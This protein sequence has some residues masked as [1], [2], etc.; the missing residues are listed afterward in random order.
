MR[1]R[2]DERHES[3]PTGQVKPPSIR[4]GDDRAARW[5]RILRAAVLPAGALIGLSAGG[6]AFLTD[7]ALSDRIWLVALVLTGGPVVIRMSRGLLAG[8]FAA[9]I[10]ATLAI[11]T[12]IILGQPLAGL[13]VVL[14]QT[15]GEALEKYAE[16][17]AS[18]A[19]RALERDA[20]RIAHRQRGDTVEDIPVESIAVG[21]ALI[22]RPGEML[23]C[24]GEVT[25]GASHL[26]TSRVT[27]EPL[28]VRVRAGDHVRSG[29]MNGE[30]SLGLRAT[31]ISAESLYARIVELVRSAEASKAPLQRL[32]DRYATYFTPFTLAMCAVA[33][34]V[35][36]DANRVLSVLVVATPC[37]LILAT[38]IAIIGGINRAASR[39]I[40]IRTGGALERLSG[41]RAIVFDKTGTMTI[42][43][44]EVAVVTSLEGRS[45]DE[46]LQLAAAV[47]RRSSHQL[48]RSVVEA[49]LGR[50]MVPE[51]VHVEESPGRGVKGRVGHHDVA[52]GALSY[53]RDVTHAD[54]VD[55]L[56]K[57][58]T[59]GLRAYVALDGR[60]SGFIEFADRLRA[61]AADEVARLRA[62]GIERI[63]LLSGDRA[64]NARAVARDVGIAEV[65][66]DLLPQEKVERVARISR[67]RP[68]A[69]VGDGTNDAPALARAD[70]GIALA[71]HGGGIT[72][73]AADIVVLSDSL[74]RVGEAIEISRRTMMIARQSIGVGLGLS[75]AA[76]VAAVAGHITPVLGALLQEVIDIA[77]IL[78]ALR[79]GARG[80]AVG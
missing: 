48:A 36:G 74:D 22:V 69:M 65:E 4:L 23:P 44:P 45:S 67:H 77:V 47:E 16:G 46:L 29:T 12:A 38:P 60:L 40:I 26:D 43:R 3:L 27:G 13:I 21:D 68:V 57:N 66:G 15:G 35:S 73:E 28:P 76:M 18:A 30:G 33:W 34:F 64:A 50:G 51:A 20:P 7:R 11:I 63:A 80:R 53:V 78:N 72:A 70:V 9:D 32:A 52:V 31:A 59:A 37:P 54:V 39:Q 75:A 19:V 14:M 6:A 5:R 62:L 17:R 10:V 56:T 55:E 58:G 1:S 71:G 79:A 2:D 41:V 49:A 8:R 25:D 61:D 42:G 24:D